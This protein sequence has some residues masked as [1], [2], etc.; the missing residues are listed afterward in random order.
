MEQVAK[1]ITRSLKLYSL[2]DSFMKIFTLIEKL[3]VSIISY[4][5]EFF[6]EN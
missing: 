1:L 3:D 4:F 2:I 5:Y 6:I